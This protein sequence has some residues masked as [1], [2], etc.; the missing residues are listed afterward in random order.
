MMM[1]P[2]DDG[3]TVDGGCERVGLCSEWRQ[4]TESNQEFLFNY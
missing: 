4:L 3:I 1:A 2:G